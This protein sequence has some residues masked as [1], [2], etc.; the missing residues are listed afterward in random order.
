MSAIIAVAGPT[1]KLGGRIVAALRREG[2][3]V[4]A[5]VRPDINE[6]QLARLDATGAIAVKVDLGHPQDVRAALQDA[7]TV[8]SALKGLREV[9]IDTQTALLDAAVAT[10]VKRFI[11]S[12]YDTDFSKTADQPNRNS[13]LRRAFYAVLDAAP[14]QAL[15]IYNGMVM[16][17]LAD[18]MPL[19][20]AKAKSVTYWGDADQLLDFTTM[21]DIAAVTAKAALDPQGQRFVRVAGDQL[22]PRQLAALGTKLTGTPFALIRA[23][24][25]DDLSAAIE[26][27]RA[28]DPAGETEEFPPFQ[29]LQ[30]LRNMMSGK[31]K[32][33]PL[34]NDRYSGIAWTSAHDLLSG[35]LARQ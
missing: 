33:D 10:G 11:P 25:I 29:Q 18:N 1:G 3:T 34:D 8:V 13:D 9:M 2:A 21:D 7:E 26:T 5:L 35:V 24:S 15:S 31:A 19:F 23:G 4:W 30:Y 17:L 32:L 16:D 12:D 28:A 22:S 6:D 27:A 14:I 20:D